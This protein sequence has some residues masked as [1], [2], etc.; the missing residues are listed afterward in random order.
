MVEHCKYQFCH[1][2]ESPTLLSQELHK[3]KLIKPISEYKIHKFTLSPRITCLNYLP[4]SDQAEEKI[5]S[6]L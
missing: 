2:V 4:P 3:F 5:L 6:N 1:D